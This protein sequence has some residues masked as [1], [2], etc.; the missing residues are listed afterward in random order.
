MS[1]IWNYVCSPVV[2]LPILLFAIRILT[3]RIARG[4]FHRED[5][6]LGIEFSFAAIFSA[7]V[8]EFDIKA[9]EAVF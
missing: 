5:C 8:Y 4:R 9:G 3:N 2:Y 7:V 6:L 1:G